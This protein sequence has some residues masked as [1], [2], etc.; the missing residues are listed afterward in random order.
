VFNS[1]RGKI[2]IIVPYGVIYSEIYAS[3]SG[4]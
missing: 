4:L 2:V 1:K 3:K